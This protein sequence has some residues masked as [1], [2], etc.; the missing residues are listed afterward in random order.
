MLHKLPHNLSLLFYSLFSSFLNY[1]VWNSWTFWGND[2]FYGPRSLYFKL[3][4]FGS[5]TLCIAYMQ[6][7]ALLI[8]LT[9]DG[10][11]AMK[12]IANESNGWKW[13]P[14]FWLVMKQHY[15]GSC[16]FSKVAAKLTLMVSF[17]KQPWSSYLA[18]TILTGGRRHPWSSIWWDSWAK[19]GCGPAPEELATQPATA[20]TPVITQSLLCLCQHKQQTYAIYL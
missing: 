4:L 11:F 2:C 17:M 3:L 6:I 19:S 13:D 16:Y 12:W 10:N 20:A 15:Y 7:C 14:W 8:K 9:I 1:K 5:Q 18:G